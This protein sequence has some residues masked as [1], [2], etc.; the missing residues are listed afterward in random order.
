[1]HKNRKNIHNSDVFMNFILL[2]ESG[3]YAIC[4]TNLRY[5]NV[6]SVESHGSS[7]INSE[8][9]FNKRINFLPLHNYL[10]SL[11]RKRGRC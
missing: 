11:C 6:L 2:K 7:K 1:M 3:K 10:T 4:I 8:F 9:G 5:F